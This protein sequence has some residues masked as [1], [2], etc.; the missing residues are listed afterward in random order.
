MLKTSKRNYIELHDWDNLVTE[1]YGKPYSFQQQNGCQERGNYT[2]SVPSKYTE[3]EDM[4]DSIPE[5]INGNTMGVKFKV[6]LETDPET[7]KKNN[8]WSDWDVDLFWERNF[9]PDIH[10]LANDLYKKKLIKKGEYTI[11]IDW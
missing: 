8:N 11:N 1:T 3:D 2:I 5:K 6:W 4:N 9:Y 7:H 10:T